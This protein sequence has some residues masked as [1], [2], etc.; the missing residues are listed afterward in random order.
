MNKVKDFFDK[1]SKYI[2]DSEINR[3]LL[4]G[5]F[6]EL[7]AFVLKATKSTKIY[8]KNSVYIEKAKK[9]IDEHYYEPMTLET[10]AKAVSLHPNYFHKVFKNS[11][12]ITPREYL[13]KIRLNNAKNFLL[14]T[15]LSVEE[16]S[17]KYT[18]HYL[19]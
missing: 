2:D 15:T 16:I 10:I 7:L 5:R 3:V 8:S 4:R 18:V 12:G 17:L 13:T 11:F 14:S 6:Y 19:L 1:Y 9:Y